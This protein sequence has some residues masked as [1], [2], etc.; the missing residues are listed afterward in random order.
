MAHLGEALY[1]VQNEVL[2]ARQKFPDN[3]LLMVALTE[4]VG[5]LA[6]ALLD[7]TPERVYAEAIQVACVALRIATEGDKSV[8]E[9]RRRRGK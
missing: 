1:D 4:E 6:K 3:D 7:E 5:E 2:R 8:E 9:W